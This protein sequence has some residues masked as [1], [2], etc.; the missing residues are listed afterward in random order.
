M[1]KQQHLFLAAFAIA[2][3]A[4][5]CSCSND[6]ELAA[7]QSKS[8]HVFTATMEGNPA[9]RATFNSENKCASWEKTDKINVNGKSYS[10]RGEGLTT[11]FVAD[12]ADA[13]GETFEV[14]YPAS[15][16]NGGTPTLPA[17][18]TETWAEGKFNMP[19]YA[20]STTD[21]L[22]F[23]NLCGVLRISVA[24]DKFAS[25]KSIKVSSQDKAV[26]GAFE[27]DVEH[28]CAAVLK[29]TD[30]PSENAV[31]V[32]YNNAVSTTSDGTIFYV[33]IPAQSYTGLKIELFDDAASPNTFSK[34]ISEN[35]V[36]IE[37]S[38]IYTV[39]IGNEPLMLDGHEYVEI[40]G[41]KWATMNVGATTVAGSAATC[42]GDYYAWGEVEPRYSGIT[43]RD[44]TSITFA[45]WT[46][47]NGY[48]VNYPSFTGGALDANNDYNVPYVK[49]SDKWRTPTSND[50]YGLYTACGGE[51]YDNGY[52]F[53]YL[54]DPGIDDHVERGVYLC[55]NYDNIRGFLFCDGIHKVFFPA[56]GYISSKKYWCDSSDSGSKTIYWTNARQNG[57]TH[58]HDIYNMSFCTTDYC[59]SLNL[60]NGTDL[61]KTISSI[62]GCV[63]RPVSYYSEED[64]NE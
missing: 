44:S 36:T 57:D 54:T 22:E 9:T 63:V 52:G 64:P 1:K 5:I 49:W 48:S 62:Y 55:T 51:D 35:A 16:Y 14:Y 2:A 45:G 40:D 30:N 58:K 17:S 61:Y 34:I 33:A 25:V 32:T 59:R 47:S 29:S 46:D 42:Y 20:T 3:M 26:S 10:S 39:Y 50:Y 21:E 7:G 37:R 4:G 43:S 41:V 24:N 38:K 56:A 6:D 60:T 19:M 15:L 13:E 53:D 23:K 18:I 27:V 31:V 11:T 28:G 12:G 8:I